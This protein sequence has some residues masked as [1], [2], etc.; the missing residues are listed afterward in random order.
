MRLGDFRYVHIPFENTE[1]A[2][3]ARDDFS[4]KRSQWLFRLIQAPWLVNVGTMLGRAALWLRLPVTPLLKATFFRQFVGG[5]TIEECRQ[6][7]R[8]L[9]KFRVGSILDYSV[10]AAENEPTFDKTTDEILKTIGLATVEAHIPF[11]V[12]KVTGVARL[13]LL[14]KIQANEVLTFAEMG[15][16]QRARERIFRICN[17]A[18][19]NN[20]SLFID[21]EETWIQDPIDR[22]AE[23]MMA[24]FNK[25]RALIFTTVQ[26]YR[27]DRRAYLEK[28][29]QKAKIAKHFFGIKLV[30][31]AYMEKERARAA[32]L[33]YPSPIHATKADT[34]RAFD[35]SLLYLM[36]ELDTVALCLGTHNLK[37]TQLLTE[38]I[39][40]RRLAPTDPRLFFAQLYGMGDHLSFPLAEGGFNVAKY[41][42]YGPVRDVF[43]Y[44]VRRAQEN[45]SIA[46][47]S[48][49]ELQLITA[50]INRRSA[51]KLVSPVRT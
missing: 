22:V 15:E 2:F 13:G 41:I 42:P 14:E 43:P 11:C 28:A 34:D 7:I 29:I 35:A 27:T 26:M 1:V 18:H 36:Y 38:Q 37:S 21:A 48:S 19:E 47:Q 30:R 45:T 24:L 6:T 49:R 39:E 33:N 3:R 40:E 31:G 20:V 12:F 16:W 50:E 23:E 5:E 10:E 46:G 17:R 4:L 25:R 44:L 8:E 51:S 32:R 9:G